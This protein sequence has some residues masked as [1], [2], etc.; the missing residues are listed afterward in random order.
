MASVEEA[1]PAIANVYVLSA[2]AAQAFAS[3]RIPGVTVT[4]ELLAIA[5]REAAAADRGRSFF[6]DL[7]AR[8]IAIARG[9][10]FRGA[11][12]GGHLDAEA[13]DEIL[14]RA[15]RFAPDDWR[16]LARELQF[17]LPDEFY[18]YERDAGTGL[19]SNEA[20]HDYVRSKQRARRRDAPL[21]YRLSRA[22]HSL[23]FEDGAPLH[24][25][26]R[27]LYERVEQAPAPVGRALHALEQAGKVPIFG[28]RD[29]GDCSLPDIAYLCPESQ[30]AKNQRNG[31][32]GGTRD[33][34]CEVGTKECIWALAY[35][36][37]KP[38]G[39]ETTMLDGPVVIKDNDLRGTSAWGNTF[40]G[41]DHHAR[42]PED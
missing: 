42:R 4:D 25:A 27:R 28:C 35:D 38:Y 15:A 22:V 39:E 9:L 7:A 30:C 12:I 31:P 6:F 21:R 26:G 34:L 1:V 16:A 24:D 3:G 29:C 11:Y 8:Q 37:L 20:N 19:S 41:R 36:R 2:R 14:D 40:L 10:G 17:G 5:Q 32:C 18:Y 33:G 23:V 13:Y